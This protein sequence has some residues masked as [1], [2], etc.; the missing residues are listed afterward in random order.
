VRGQA[1]LLR[2]DRTRLLCLL[3]FCN[4]F[5]LGAFGPLL[6]EIGRTQS[7][8]DWQLGLVAAAVGFARMIAAMPTGLLVGRRLAAT[9]MAGPVVIVVGL[10]LLVG[11]GPFSMLLAG[12]FLLG[13]A[14]T[15]TMIGG[16]TAMLSRTG[17][18]VGQ[19]QLLRVLRHAGRPGRPRLS[20]SFSGTD[21]RPRCSSLDA[22][23][24]RYF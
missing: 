16:L 13:I 18:R 12:R 7:L 10:T 8:P 3:F 20:P 9:L 15:L 24:F 19:A 17:P 6:P 4:A 11:A 1:G 23:A 5:G 2:L 14:Q 21:G 22:G